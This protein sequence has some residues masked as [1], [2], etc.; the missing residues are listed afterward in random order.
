MPKSITTKRKETKHHNGINRKVQRSF[1]LRVEPERP[2]NPLFPLH[3]Q[4]N[5]NNPAT[6]AL[7][8]VEAHLKT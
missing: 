7:R 8:G 3:T 4:S 1:V 2:V 5:Q 6:Q